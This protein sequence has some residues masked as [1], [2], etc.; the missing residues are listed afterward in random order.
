MK[1]CENDECDYNDGVDVCLYDVIVILNETNVPCRKKNE[2]D[3][4]G[5][6]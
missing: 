3:K 6:E 2:T 1:W 5:D 4:E